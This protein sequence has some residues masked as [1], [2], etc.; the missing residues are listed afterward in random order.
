MKG[1]IVKGIAGFYYVYAEDLHIYECKAKG[2]FRKEKLKP[3]VGDYVEIDILDDCDRIGNI[4]D[5]FPRSNKLIR[6]FVSNVDQALMVFALTSPKPNLCLL[7][8]LLLQFKIQKVPTIICFNKEDLVDDSEVARI[9]RIYAGSNCR[10]IFTCA[11]ENVGIDE[12]KELL[13]GK[14]TCVAGP[15]GV[16]KSSIIN[17]LQKSV[18]VE[19]G[20]ISRKLERGKHTTRH[21]EIIPIGGDG[22]VCD[23][24]GFS[25]FDIFL[26]DCYELKDYYDEFALEDSCRFVPCS[27]THEP[28]CIVKEKVINGNIPRERYDNYV[29]IFEELK[30]L[31]RY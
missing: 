19:T 13:E 22:Y 31:R 7:D 25:S 10:V 16:G 24:P 9:G 21:S 14:L 3:M 1:R 8:K 20:V 6:P 18:V 12:L 26:E 15:S 2:V 11:K 30:K 5:I 29:L 23:T 17:C 27:H 4:V 28:G